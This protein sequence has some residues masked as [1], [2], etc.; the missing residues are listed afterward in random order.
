MNVKSDKEQKNM[1]K[2]FKYYLGRIIINGLFLLI[3]LLLIIGCCCYIC[4]HWHWVNIIISF[5]A[6]ILALKIAVMK[7]NIPCRIGWIIGIL[8]LPVLFIPMYILY[9]RGTALKKILRYLRNNPLPLSRS[10]KIDAPLRIRK[11]FE[12][13]SAISGFPAYTDSD[14]EYYPTGESFF[15]AMKKDLKSAERYIFLEFFIINFGIMWD[16]TLAI[17]EEKIK[18]GVKVYILYDD[19][20][21]IALL[22]PDFIKQMKDK[23]INAKIFNL[24][25]GKITPKINYRDHRKIIVVDGKCAIT[26]G[27][28]IADEYI[29]KTSP[30]G[31]WKDTAI[32]VEGKSADTFAA[33][34]IQMWNMN[35]N[36]LKYEDFLGFNCESSK[37][38]SSAL[39]PFG[40]YP[41]YSIGFTE[42]A[43]LNMINNAESE[44]NITTP[45]LIPDSRL[46]SAICLASENGI[47]V[48][49]FTPEIPDKKYIHIIT[50]ANYITLLKCGVE[51]Y[52][53]SDGFIH[54]KSILCDNEIAYVGSANLDYRSLYIHF[55]SGALMY[56]TKS[57]SQ[58]RDDI[59]GLLKSSKKISLDDPRI[60]KADKN[61]I[62]RFLRIFS[63][64]L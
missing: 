54:A 24:F 7:C 45:Y 39:L 23:G 60:V 6:L 52:E 64:L 17:L 57:V 11:Q 44:I 51:V 13:L 5:A 20:G 62:Y 29:N 28:N 35:G 3:Q 41:M 9:G 26:G 50:R 16:E 53:F 21:T 32:R 55:E 42:R 4:I 59:K 58:L 43:F 2:L 1:K 36:I 30:Y 61:I 18:Q 10:E 15:E 48:R 14:C 34:F 46:L 47:K 22:P 40:D 12:G 33:M 25:N 19:L 56:K 31:Y 27:A 8:F 63:G 38:N 49:L 37:T